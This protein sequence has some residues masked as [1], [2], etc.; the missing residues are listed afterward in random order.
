[1]IKLA[2]LCIKGLETFIEPIAREL[3]CDERYQVVR[4]YANKH[5]EIVDA[6][7]WCDV[8]W[9]EWANE[10]AILATQ[11]YDIRHKHVICRFHSYEAFTDMPSK[12]NWDMVDKCVFVA[13]HVYEM[14][15]RQYPNMRN[16]ESCIIP[17]GV[18]VDV[19]NVK[20]SN[21]DIAYVA[22]ISHKK[23][24]VMMLQIADKLRVCR[25]RIH[26]AGEYQ[27]ERYRRYMNYAMARMGID[28]VLFYGHVENMNEF[29]GSKG[30]ILSTSIHE[31]HPLNI[32]E[33]MAH[34]LKPVILNFDG[35]EGLYPEKWL[36][37][38]VDEAVAMLRVKP[39]NPAAYWG[40]IHDMGWT[41]ESQMRDITTI[42][43]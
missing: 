19:D 39:E 22:N 30:Y 40:Y 27:D 31:G 14:A 37:N 6:V 3:E 29:Y 35:A 18:E 7:K 11:V 32:S 25:K 24:P 28:N 43:T 12:V 42:I 9:V 2:V 34:G 41:R 15:M 36:Y 8:L 16:V 4:F 5:E 23:N 10:A 21:D 38:T 33:G 26:V 1:M 20:R 13:R 17:N